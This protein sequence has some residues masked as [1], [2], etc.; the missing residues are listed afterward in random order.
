MEN[1]FPYQ[2]HILNNFDA[3]WIVWIRRWARGEDVK[4]TGTSLL[5]VE[6]KQKNLIFA[7]AE[8]RQKSSL[9]RTSIILMILQFDDPRHYFFYRGRTQQHFQRL[10]GSRVVCESI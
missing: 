2:S 6:N 7:Y 10:R 8:L 9:D 4:S 1:G 5:E 3:L